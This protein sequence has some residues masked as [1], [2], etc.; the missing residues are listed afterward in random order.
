MK[1]N[2]LTPQLLTDLLDNFRLEADFEILIFADSLI[3][4]FDEW[5]VLIWRDRDGNYERNGDLTI[6][7]KERDGTEPRQWWRKYVPNN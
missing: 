2:D 7:F 6:H 1:P 4:V 5:E 3:L